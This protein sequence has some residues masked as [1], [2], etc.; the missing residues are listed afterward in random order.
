MSLADQASLLLIPSG[1]KS[2]K[3]YSIFPTDGDGDFDF[4]RSGSATRIAKNGLITTVDSNVPR[5]EYPM[6]DGVQKGCPS[7]KLE[8]QRTNLI[9]YSSDFPRTYWTKSGASIQGD[10]STQGSEEITNGS[11]ATD[12]DWTKGTGWTISGGK[13]VSNSSVGYQSLSQSNAISNSNGKTFKCNFTISG[14]S[15]GLVA[16][17][18]SGFINNSY[19]IGANGD[20]EIYIM[21]SQGTSGNVEFLTNS[22]GFV[23]SIDNVSIK[24]VQGFTS[25][26]GTTNA[27]KLVED[28]SNGQHQI[29]P[30]PSSGTDAVRTISFFVKMDGVSKIGIRAGD[31]KYITYDIVNGTTLDKT[32]TNNIVSS[33]FNNGWKK[34]SIAWDSTTVITG[35]RIFL[36]NDAYTSGNPL[37]YSYTGDGTSGVYL[38]GAQV[39]EGS[40]QTSYIPTNGSATT[41]NAETCNGAG[42]SAIFNDSE[43]VLMAEISALADDLVAEGISI[44]DE[45]I[46]NRVVI[47]KWTTTNSIKVR[48]ASGGTNYF[49]KTISVSDIT[50]INKIAIKYKQNDFSLWVNGFELETDTSGITPIGLSKLNFNGATSPSAFYG[51]T[52][53]IQ[54]YNSVLTESE[55]SQLTSWTSFTDMAEGQLYTIE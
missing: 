40:F 7:L 23:G 32:I 53:Q 17:Y 42:D 15:S 27:Y 41:R 35:A 12:S 52:K 13:A 51:N 16:L 24:E 10:P 20:Y 37:T 14:Y 2:Q 54:Y 3:V 33:D 31:A 21:V 50:T 43:G 28:A 39:E 25:P 36:L 29:F 6:I 47:F 44:S 34:L 30:T 5:L 38:F 26:D 18:I 55:L 48:V 4:S 8:P 45:T 1:Y 19:F 46:G 9:T 11:F 22:S 49:D